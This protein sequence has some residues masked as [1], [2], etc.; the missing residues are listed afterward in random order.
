MPG[1]A[2]IGDGLELPDMYGLRGS[3]ALGWMAGQRQTVTN[4][5]DQHLVS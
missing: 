2:G 4:A 5:H 1:V 3:Q